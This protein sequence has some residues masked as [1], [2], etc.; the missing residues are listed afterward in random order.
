MTDLRV[1]LVDDHN[2]LRAGLKLLLEQ[3]GGLQVI[4]E[5]SRGKPLLDEI[6]S[7]GSDLVLL[8]ISLPDISGLDVLLHIRLMD[9]GLEK[10]PNVLML[11][12]HSQ[13]EYVSRALSIGASGYLLKESA[14]D[15]LELALCAVLSGNQW[16]SPALARK[17]TEV[18]E[19]GKS[20]G[21]SKDFLTARQLDVL[22]LIA[23]GFC[24]KEIAL[25][26]GISAKT[27]ESH[28]IQLMAR[29]GIRDIPKLTLYAARIGLVSL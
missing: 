27:V 12:M 10:A 28:R 3:I 25:E 21:G 6:Q 23:S 13:N 24:T 17:P 26:L 8:D 19:N 5:F 18:A 2:L 7:L 22:R 1:V 14:P 20:L 29:L 9:W 15:E 4:A 11:S 16:L